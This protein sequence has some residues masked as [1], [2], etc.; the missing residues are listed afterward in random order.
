[1]CPSWRNNYPWYDCVFI[2]INPELEG[3]AG[4]TIAR[5]ICFFS[6]QS[7]HT[8]YPCAVVHWFDTVGDAPDED[9][10]L[11]M[12]HLAFCA[13]HTPDITVIHIDAIYRAAHLI[14]IYGRHSVPPDIKYYHSYDTFRA[15]YVDKYADHHAFEIAF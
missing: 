5:V 8:L 12:V 10:G 6:F 9:T 14:P 3:M 13:N 15:F 2:N 1:A 4:M 7:D 11:W